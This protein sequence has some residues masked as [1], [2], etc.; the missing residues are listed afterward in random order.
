MRRAWRSE[1]RWLLAGL[2]SVSLSAG[3]AGQS[4]TGRPPLFS[5]LPPSAP[6]PASPRT[7]Y[8]SAS[9][10]DEHDGSSR[11]PWRT[12]DKINRTSLEPGDTVAFEGGSSFR[13]NLVIRQSGTVALPIQVTSHP[14]QGGDQ[15]ELFAGAGDGITIENAEH[16][17]VSKI[18]VTGSGIR[19]NNGY[20]IRLSRTVSGNR[21]LNSIYLDHVET[22]GFRM[23]GITMDAGSHVSV[24]Y[25]D[26]RITHSSIYGNGYAGVWMG[27]C[28]A[29]GS[30][31]VY[32]FENVYAGYNLIHD[33]PGIDIEEQTGNG[34]FFK[35]VDGGMIEHC[36]A[37]N[38]GALNKNAGG[39]P[40][41]IWAIFSNNITI[42]Y[43]E[44]YQNH[45]RAND[46]NGFDLDGGV[47]NSRMQYNYSHDNDGGGYLLSDWQD[48]MQ[49]RNNI[50]RYNISQNDGRAGFFGG[51]HL[52][53][54]GPGRL[55]D[56][57][58]YGNTVYS[59]VHADAA[60]GIQGNVSNVRVHN[61]I[62]VAGSGT[63][64]VH[65]R[66]GV[67][68]VRMQ[69][70]VYW[71]IGSAF[72]FLW[73]GHIYSSLASW[74]AATGQERLNSA[75]T[76][77]Q[78]DPGLVAAGQGGTIGDT[79]RLFT[80]AAYQLSLASPL[81]DQGLNLFALGIDPGSR[82]FYGNPIPQA[83]GFDIGAHELMGVGS[84]R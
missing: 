48:V 7:Y 69:G 51:I 59:D 3:C 77:F 5:S 84:A 46:G 29:S 65:S 75:D 18:K 38:N 9:G 49:S 76:G 56:V 43:N 68:G 34:I 25:N 61:N 47:T 39:G 83:A 81:R 64:I 10:D 19:S 6:S 50:V 42:Q 58:I 1:R 57:Q 4:D 63:K 22:S 17:R 37:Y 15:A 72:Q 12:I 78:L 13:G 30:Q 23:A 8:L 80:L 16:I 28:G 79:D 31:G 35:D 2:V 41:G 52:A 32:C 60:F 53:T 21:R 54:T 67:A 44:S 82:D 24:G 11:G 66:G 73:N 71:D 55:T 45:T 62:F 40:V 27:G 36:S 74:R 20:G 33:N 70:N 26:I 14:T